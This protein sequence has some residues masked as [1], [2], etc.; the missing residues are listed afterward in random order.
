[1]NISLLSISGLLVPLTSDLS[2]FEISHSAFK[3][4]LSLSIVLRAVE[5]A[6]SSVS[7]WSQVAETAGTIIFEVMM[8]QCTS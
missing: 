4:L 7:H 5:E 2:R 6:S 3:Q 8:V 1:M